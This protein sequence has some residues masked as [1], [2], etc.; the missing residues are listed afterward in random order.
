MNDYCWYSL[1]VDI[2]SALKSD[3]KFPVPDAPRRSW[4]YLPTDILSQTWID[5]MKHQYNIDVNYVLVFYCDPYFSPKTAHIDIKVSVTDPCIF[6]MNWVVAGGDTSKM[7]WYHT[8]S[9]NRE[10]R[11]TEIK[12]A[13]LAWDHVTL[14]ECDSY[15]IT[16][17]LTL[18]RTDVPHRI[19]STTDK[20]W[21]FSVRVGNTDLVDWD[22][23]VDHMKSQNI[24]ISRN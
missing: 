3:W 11:Y 6:A 10:L 20:R 9:G 14:N 15:T 7:Y 1:N 23:V 5:T 22:K 24:L 4:G 19:E 16:N 18:V 8:P 2:S 12:T 21:C 17:N 13:Y